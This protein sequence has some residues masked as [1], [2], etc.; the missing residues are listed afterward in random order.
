[1]P[2]LFKKK[3]MEQP[4]LIL[5][6]LASFIEHA[7]AKKQQVPEEFWKAEGRQESLCALCLGTRDNR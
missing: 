6:N 7:K 5:L 2:T 4:S 3:Y 1:M